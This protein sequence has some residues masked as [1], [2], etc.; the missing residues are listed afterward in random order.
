MPLSERP[1]ITCRQ[2]IDFIYDYLDG[3]LP[4]D[5][6]HEFERHLAVCP[7]CVHYLNTYRQT[8]RISKQALQ[9]GMPDG[10]ND[11]GDGGYDGSDEEQSAGVLPEA[12]V[13]SILSTLSQRM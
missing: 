8:M 9:G 6:Q 2:L 11:R 3:T 4:T 12:L 1:Y 7:S 5:E 13:Q 10:G